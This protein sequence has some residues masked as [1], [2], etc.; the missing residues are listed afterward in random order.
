MS[1]TPNV[2]NP[3]VHRSRQEENLE[4]QSEELNE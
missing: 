4:A 3:C 2:T 1:E